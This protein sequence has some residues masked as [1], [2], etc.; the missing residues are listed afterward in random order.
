MLRKSL[1]AG[2]TAVAIAA[3]STFAFAAPSSAA[4]VTIT[5]GPNM[6]TYGMYHGHR[7]AKV[8]RTKYE[9][10]HHHKVAVGTVC[11]WR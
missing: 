8:C 5:F 7:H 10:H 4:S 11:H 1:T 3:A 9:W 2:V 6:T